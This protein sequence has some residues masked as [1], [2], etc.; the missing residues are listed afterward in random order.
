M[1]SSWKNPACMYLGAGL[2]FSR[3]KPQANQSW[4]FTADKYSPGYNLFAGLR[5]SDHFFAEFADFNLG[6]ANLKKSNPK[7]T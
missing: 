5:L 4:W 3:V 7:I 1:Q 2:G 6:E